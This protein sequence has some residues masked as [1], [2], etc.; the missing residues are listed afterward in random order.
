VRKQSLDMAVRNFKPT[1]TKLEKAIAAAYSG[2]AQP[3]RIEEVVLADGTR[4]SKV[5]IG[6]VSYCVTQRSN[7]LVGGRDVFRDGVGSKVTN[8]PS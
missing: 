7:G 8:C 4:M 2:G 1:E 6:K 5:T 3:T